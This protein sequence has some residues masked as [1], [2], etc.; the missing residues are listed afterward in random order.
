MGDALLKLATDER[1]PMAATGLGDI[2]AA[3]GRAG[4]HRK[5]IVQFSRDAAKI[6]V[7]FDLSGAQ[8]GAAM[9]G[10]RS[11][12]GLNQEQAVLVADSYNHLSNNMDATAG[13]ILRVTARA[14]SLGKLVGFSGQQ[15]G[16]LGATFLALKTP[17]EVTATGINALISKLATADKQP[18]RL[19]EALRTLGLS[20]SELKRGMKDDAQGTLL[21]FLETVK[22]SDD[23]IGVLADLFGAEYADDVAKLVGS[24]DV[25]KKALKLVG[26]EANFAGSAQQEYEVRAKTTANDLQ[27]LKNQAQRFAITVGSQLLPP[28]KTAVSFL[29]HV[30][31]V[32]TSVA[33]QFPLLTKAVGLAAITMVGFKIAA[34]GSRF[35]GTLF[36]D[37]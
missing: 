7:A 15:I 34:L 25:Y 11:I 35:A 14:G 4:I 6:G 1:I 29:G 2:A 33:E 19:A 18:E 9:S 28:L 16:A 37:A 3:A 20:A 17:P 32:V 27:I 8:A 10:L 22:Q 23:Q 31:D 21:S 5:E 26:K 24:L 30:A 13:E 36:S 12:F